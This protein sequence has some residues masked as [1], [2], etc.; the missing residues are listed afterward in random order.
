MFHNSLLLG[1]AAWIHPGSMR[2]RPLFA[3]WFGSPDE[4]YIEPRCFHMS[5]SIEPCPIASIPDLF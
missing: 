4:R 2:F 1:V 5:I 3:H